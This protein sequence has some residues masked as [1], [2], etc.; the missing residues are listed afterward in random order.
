MEPEWSISG[1]TSCALPRSV[2]FVV[3]C[4]FIVD[5]LSY[6][7][8]YKLNVWPVLEHVY[9]CEGVYNCTHVWVCICHCALNQYWYCVLCYVCICDY[10]YHCMK[11]HLGV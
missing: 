10:M 6:N 9:V 8:I 2:C 3:G 11:V 4:F 7:L 1:S 5:P